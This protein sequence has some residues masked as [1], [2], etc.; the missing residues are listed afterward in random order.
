MTNSPLFCHGQARNINFV[1]FYCET[2]M[3]CDLREVFVFDE[4]L[5]IPQRRYREIASILYSIAQK[6]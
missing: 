6:S 2:L 4:Q 3:V 1:P 5:R